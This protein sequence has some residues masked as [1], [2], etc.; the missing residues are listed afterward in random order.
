M[1][2]IFSQSVVATTLTACIDHYPPLQIVA[3]EP[4]G[5][6]I[7][8]LKVLAKVTNRELEIVVGP[9]F[10]RCLRLLELGKVDILAGLI[11][12]PER[13]KIAHLVSYQQDTP[14]IFVTRKNT[15]EIKK[16]KDLSGLVIGITTNTL[17]FKQ[18]DNDQ[19]LN[20]VIIKDINT[21]FKM[22]TKDRIDVVVTAQKI[23]SNMVNSPKSEQTLKVNEYKPLSNRRLYFGISKKNKAQ[24]TP[25]EFSQIEAAAE[26]LLFQRAIEEFI[27]KNPQLY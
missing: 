1:C 7:T 16:Y 22:L 15:K 23:Y 5:E 10:A 3:E 27:I 17:Y 12:S 24:L 9:N 13:R 21:G 8:A 20:K 2:F 26:Q 6:N 11:D 4:Y 25:V 18:F 19:T 14:Y